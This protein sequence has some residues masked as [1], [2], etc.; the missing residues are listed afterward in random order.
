[1]GDSFTVQFSFKGKSAY[2]D[3]VTLATSRVDLIDEARKAYKTKSDVLLKLLFKKE[4]IAEEITDAEGNIGVINGPAFPP[5]AEVGRMGAKVSVKATKIVKKKVKEDPNR[6][7]DDG[8]WGTYDGQLDDEGLRNGAGK[9]VWEDGNQYDGEWKN[10][11]QD[12]MGLS[13]YSNGGSYSGEH[14]R[15]KRHGVG[16]YVHQNG[17]VYEGEYKLL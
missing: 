13:I 7:R 9:M 4:T 3:D 17:D 16:K 5:D 8:V 10:D 2:L 15:G 12:G 11:K 14:R 6:F 1:M